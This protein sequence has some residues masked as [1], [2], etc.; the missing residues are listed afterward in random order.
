M[1]SRARKGADGAQIEAA[2]TTYIPRWTGWVTGELP[3][4]EIG[5]EQL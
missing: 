2:I 4:C 5:Y 3:S 1:S